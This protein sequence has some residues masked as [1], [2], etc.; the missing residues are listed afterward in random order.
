LL[1][2]PAAL[3]LQLGGVTM[4]RELLISLNLSS[5]SALLVVVNEGDAFTCGAAPAGTRQGDPQ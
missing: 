4:P 2:L 5:L 3:L 1:L